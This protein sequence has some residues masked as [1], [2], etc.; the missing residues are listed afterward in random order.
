MAI[1]NALIIE[2]DDLLCDHLLIA[3]R[4]YGSKIKYRKHAL[5]IKMEFIASE[6][7]FKILVNSQ[8]ED[9]IETKIVI[10]GEWKNVISSHII[11][12][13]EWKN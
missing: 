3:R 4:V 9:V 6:D 1:R 8:W 13:G 11:V 12:D 10:N 2:R 7:V 5:V